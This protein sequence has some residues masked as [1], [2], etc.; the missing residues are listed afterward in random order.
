MTAPLDNAQMLRQILESSP[1]CV[2]IMD[3]DARLVWM[4]GP[5]KLA[6]QID[7]SSS[8]AGAAWLEF[9]QGEH[10][11]S[12]DAAVASALA[13]GTGR[14]SGFC[15]TSLGEPRWW[16]VIVTP[17]R[18]ASGSP[19]HLLSVSRD[20]S[21]AKRDEQ[22]EAAKREILVAIAAQEPLPETLDRIAQ[23]HQSFNPDSFCSLQVMD[24]SGRYL[25]R[26]AAPSLPESFN[27]S[28]DGL[29][30]GLGRGSAAAAAWSR[31]SL[32]ARDIAS[33]P[34][35][36]GLREIALAQG[37]RACWSTPV[38][39]NDG[40]VLGTFSVYYRE[41]QT[42]AARDRESI[43]RALVVTRVALESARLVDRLRERDHFFELSLELF[44]IFDSVAGRFTQVNRALGE[45]TGFSAEE[46]TSRYFQEFV[47]P[48]DRDAAALAA[49]S[50][51]GEG[52]E[53]NDY[54]VRFLCRDGGYRWLQWSARTAQ[55]GLVYAAGRDITEQ[56]KVDMELAHAVSHDAITGL[57]HHLVFERKLAIVLDEATGP[58]WILFIGLDHFQSINESMGHGI[59]DE[60]LLRVAERLRAELGDAG[61]IARF[62]GDEFV[63]AVTGFDQ[64]SVLGLAERLRDAISK[65]IQ[66]GEYQLLV[67]ASVGISQSPD[68]GRT[69]QE[70][71]RRA[72]AA[73]TRAKRQGRDCVR[74]FSTEQMQDI[75]DR[76]VLGS[77]LRGAV[78]R[79]ELELHYQPQHRADDRS[80]CGFEAL[81]RWNN[82]S[83]GRVPPSRFVPVAE[84]LG[85]MSEIGAWV[86]DEACRQA[87]VWLDCGHRGF[88]ISV[89]VAAQQLQRTG[90]VA[91]VR[92]AI[93][94]HALPKGALTIELTESS[95]MENVMRVQNV[96]A[97]LKALGIQLSLDDFGTGYSS[98]AYLK[99]FPIDKLKIDQ[100]FVRGLPDDGDDAT[101][102]RTIV[103]MAHQL[104]LVVAAEGVETPAQALFLKDIGCDELQGYLLGRPVPAT[105]AEAFFRV[106]VNLVM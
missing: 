32:V 47:H 46:M 96:L 62:A 80:L 77:Q 12:A 68:H 105:E 16:D 49:A 41:P 22:I 5:G 54:V 83:L 44:C 64:A 14:F 63:V 58:V 15:P 24:A 23:L 101:I 81:L 30:I 45:V 37:L 19:K 74:E 86:L 6:M 59:G 106:P 13:G 79:G 27:A 89:N 29:E 67:T 66:G 103:A 72:E 7:L 51:D 36:A 98:L 85:L 1:D 50:L 75:E 3:L 76:L 70:L 60:L 82:P 102:A 9:W 8:V 90:L 61:G 39:G 4:N 42:P 52:R 100:S 48:D 99:Q 56:K 28:M 31:E 57:P 69:P 2:K 88:D 38:L 84:A 21:E 73:M 55:D 94:R 35:W 26:G 71:L 53:L 20:I 95:L 93:E 18:D 91:Q 17:L 43:D 11:A 25:L 34:N 87:R 10:R 40:Q 33:D 104:R 78:A 97:E 92:A 65:P